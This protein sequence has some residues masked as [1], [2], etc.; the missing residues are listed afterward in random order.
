M[1]QLF[2]PLFTKWQYN[3]HTDV[4]YNIL[5]GAM[6]PRDDLSTFEDTGDSGTSELQIIRND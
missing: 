3:S 5:A 6:L 1:S 4:W 2:L